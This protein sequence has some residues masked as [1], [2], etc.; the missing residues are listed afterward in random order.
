MRRKID[1]VREG[2]QEASQSEGGHA[3]AVA[4]A[5][6]TSVKMAMGRK[7]GQYNTLK[8]E[9]KGAG[10]FASPS[11]GAASSAP[12]RGAGGSGGVADASASPGLPDLPTYPSSA[13]KP[14]KGAEK[15]RPWYRC[16][17]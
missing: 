6:L 13:S 15:A 5:S 17:C 1:G 7:G 10:C 3:A 11:G 2:V 12:P 8:E 16:C 9:Y 14:D 4:K